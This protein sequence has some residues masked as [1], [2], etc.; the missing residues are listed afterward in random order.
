MK[1]SKQ[2]LNKY[3][4]QIKKLLVCNH[5]KRKEFMNSFEDNLEEYL[6]AN[7]DADFSKLQ[8]NMGTPQEIAAAFLENESAENI[9]KRMSI[10]R[11]FKIGII[12]ALLMFAILLISIFID[13]Y[14][15][16]R[17]YGE[18]TITVESVYEDNGSEEIIV[19]EI[20]EE[21]IIEEEN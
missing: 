11:W 6:K 19:E 9:K 17:G 3:L 20:I 8:E 18:E 10:A 2:E 12:I 1:V 13:L 15:S 4:K 5:A 7:P 16:N 21:E 14:K